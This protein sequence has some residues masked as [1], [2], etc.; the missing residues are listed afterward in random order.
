MSRELEDKNVCATTPAGPDYELSGIN[1]C[2]KTPKLEL[3]G[4]KRRNF[5]LDDVS[6]A[7]H[8]LLTSTEHGL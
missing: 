8:C 2:S 7:T 6:P 4:H 3:S 5:M 1:D